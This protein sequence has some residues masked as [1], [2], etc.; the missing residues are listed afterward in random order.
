[1]VSRRDALRIGTAALAGA[2][3]PV[4]AAAAAGSPV[5]GRGCYLTFCRIPTA[6]LTTWKS[7]MDSFRADGVDRVVLW[8]GGAFRSRRYPV[9]WQ[10]NREHR[11]V[12]E[13]FAGQLID[14]AHAVGIRVLLGFTPY[15]YD[16]TNQ[17][18]YERPDL[19]A[20]Q[21][22]GNLARM[23]G[24]HSWGYNLDPTKPAARQFMLEYARELYFDFYPNADGLL[25][26]SSDIDICTGGDCDGPRHYYEVEYEFVRELSGQ[27]WAHHPGAEILVH[28]NYFVGGSNGAELPY[29]QRWS[30]IFSPWTVNLEFAKKVSRAYYFSLDMISQPPAKVAA[31]VRWVRDHGFA[32]YFPSQEFFTYRAQ[33]AEMGETNLIGQQLRP[34]GFDFLGLDENPYRDPVVLVN[35]VALREYAE[36]PDLTEDQFR[37][38]LGQAAFGP[39]ATG[40]EVADLLF[41]HDFC[42]GRDKSL[43]TLAVQAD[44]RVLRER[45]QRGLVG[46]ADLRAVHERL[47]ALPAVAARIRRSRNPAV[48]SLTRHIGLLEQNWDAEARSLLAAHLPG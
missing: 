33:H 2:V 26:E 17:Y 20:Q 4:A 6:G 31:S 32:S 42:Y 9:T 44:P 29:D 40:Q 27:V 48:R 1:M 45:L 14:Y 37:A 35:R 21:A 23:Q 34:F 5:V 19:K 18:A 16:G 28:P 10:Y 22:N 47:G 43:F 12:R 41:L 39:G 36:H 7:I 15:T 8:L 11:N 38:R 30:V 25:I 13:N 46:F 24:I 3:L